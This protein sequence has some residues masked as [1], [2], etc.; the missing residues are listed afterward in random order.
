MSHLVR[1]TNTIQ[2]GD[3]GG[4]WFSGNTAFGITNALSVNNWGIFSRIAY[5]ESGTGYV[6]CTV[7]GC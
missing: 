4:P 7:S 6:T 2:Q 1:A 3:S 5:V